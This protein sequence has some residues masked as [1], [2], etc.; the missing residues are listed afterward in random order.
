MSAR[1]AKSLLRAT[2]EDYKEYKRLLACIRDI[3][4][5]MKQGHLCERAS[6]NYYIYQDRVKELKRK[7]LAEG[8]L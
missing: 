5:R 7:L 2:S 3:E 4:R 6:W 1:D 8:L